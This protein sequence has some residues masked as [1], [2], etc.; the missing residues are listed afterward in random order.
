MLKFLVSWAFGLGV[1]VT[2]SLQASADTSPP[3]Y[4]EQLVIRAQGL[5]LSEQEEWKRL[6]HYHKA[7]YGGWVSEADGRDFFLAKDGKTEPQAELAAT[8]RGI[9]AP[10]PKDPKA[11]HPMCQFPAR[12]LWLEQQLKLDWKQ[13][14]ARRCPQFEEFLGILRPQG[15]SLV[16][17]SYYLNNPSSA[18]GHTFLRVRRGKESRNDQADL[19]DYG[20][21]FS[22][23]V[24]TQN[25]FVYGVK[26]L[27]GL[28]PG[29]FN[30]IPYYYKVREYNDHDSRDIWEY[31]LNLTPS[32]TQM[33]AAH[34]W[35]LGSTYFDYYYL[36]ENCSYHILGALQVADP[37]LKLLDKVGWPVIP[38][39]TVKALYQNPGLVGNVTY[40][41]SIRTQFSRRLNGLSP[42]ER[43]QVIALMGDP[44]APFSADF[45]QRERVRTLDTAIDLVDVKFAGEL[46]KERS[47]MDQ[48]L[49]LKQ[50]TLLER[51]AEDLVPSAEPH[52]EPPFRLMPHVGHDSA[53]VGMGSG[54]RQGLGFYHTLSFRLALHDLADP[55]PGYL[56]SAQI[57]FL[58]GTLRYYAENQRLRLEELS[59]VRVRSMAPITRFDKSLSWLVDL[60]VRR[61]ADR[62]CR[63]CTTGFGQV[64]LGFTFAPFGSW[65]NVYT[66]ANAH[67]ELPAGRGALFDFVRLGVGPWGGL[68]ISVS[69]RI[70]ILNVGAWSYLPGQHPKQT[71]LLDSALRVG[72]KRNFAFGVEGR[73]RPEEKTLQAVSYLYF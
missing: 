68:R 14:P 8:I 12:M 40:R 21:D 5:R 56:N 72:Y 36:S 10:D 42:K 52:F 62:G 57:E 24:D 23:R 58:P 66:L 67:L 30:R 63:D 43:D 15:F 34:L 9:F 71:W 48:E 38:A 29:Q 60:G 46:L 73:L 32:Q 26:G 2:T 45:G 28:F 25:A 50:Q 65:L 70:N 35:E 18:L 59:L 61:L 64:G 53:R 3:A 44:K 49:T 17:S 69:D 27:A 7:W 4:A 37:K 55:S 1:A 20:V 54:Y 11:Q 16:F 19:L 39:D 51:R 22:A 13:I 6:L 31:S 41:P 47:D 33:V